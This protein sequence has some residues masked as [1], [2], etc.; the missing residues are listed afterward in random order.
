MRLP[1]VVAFARRGVGQV[2]D[3]QDGA[4]EHDADNDDIEPQTPEHEPLDDHGADED[5]PDVQ[6]AAPYH[7]SHCSQ[8]ELTP[9]RK[10]A[11]AAQKI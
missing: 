2:V 1:I 3:T 9:R 4:C 5:N 10:K 7:P 11:E 8:L 6:H